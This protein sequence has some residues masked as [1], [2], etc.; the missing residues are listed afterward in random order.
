MSGKRA[1][2]EGHVRKRAD[3]RWEA[4]VTLP[5]GKRKSFYRKTRAEA[6]AALIVALRDLGQGMPIVA[7]KQTVGEY[8]T[9]WL[10]GAAHSLAPRSITRY[11][12]HIEHTLK[13]ALGRIRL[14]KLSPQHVQALYTDVMISAYLLR[15]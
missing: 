14:A 7:E 5:T 12:G 9:A 15:S 2:G 6:S 8:L 3:G 10:D 1:N 4:M 13:P 11:R